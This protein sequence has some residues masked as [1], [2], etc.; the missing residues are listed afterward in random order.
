[1]ADS[2]KQIAITG[3]VNKEKR[4]LALNKNIQIPDEAIP[5]GLAVTATV[6][7]HHLHLSFNEDIALVVVSGEKK[8]TITFKE[9]TLSNKFAL[10]AL[11]MLLVEKKVIDAKE[12]EKTMDN[13]RKSHFHGA[14]EAKN[15]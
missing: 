15:E 8:R 14:P 4:E 9:L 13:V 12:L 11:V 6:E 3:T 10:E 5:P 2:D 1:M 7:G